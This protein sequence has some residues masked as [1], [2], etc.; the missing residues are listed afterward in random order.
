MGL[1]SLVGLRVLWLYL[2][3]VFCFAE[4][5][6]CTLVSCLCLLGICL[7]VWVFNA[8]WFVGLLGFRY[9]NAGEL[10]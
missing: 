10:A 6:T 9:L 1:G 7:D 5:D 2:T 3:L 8:V 4:F